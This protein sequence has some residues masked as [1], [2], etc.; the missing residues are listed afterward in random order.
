MFGHHSGAE[1]IIISLCICRDNDIQN[2]DVH[3]YC[4]TW[5]H[6][7]LDDHDICQTIRQMRALSNG[8]GSWNILYGIQK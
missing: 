2:E 4:L 6:N 1:H 3:R 7:K 5:R 8:F